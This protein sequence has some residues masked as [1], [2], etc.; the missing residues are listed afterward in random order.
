MPSLNTP[1]TKQDF[2]NSRWQD[3]VHNSE[4]KECSVYYSGFCK[5]AQEALEAGNDREYAVFEILKSVTITPIQI[6]AKEDFLAR[7]VQSFSDEHLNF[8]AEIV[9]EVS[10]PEL[11][12]RIADI[13]WNSKRRN[14]QMAQLGV[15][16]YL[17]SAEESNPW[18]KFDGIFKDDPLFDDFVEEMA[19]YRRELDAEV[20]AYE[21]RSLWLTMPL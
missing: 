21:A 17:K 9:A 15:T 19:A 2:I 3:V 14:Y 11:Q 18:V 10:D 16:G 6:E 20:E 7:I 4:K 5:K 13:L 8:L 1:L 12:A